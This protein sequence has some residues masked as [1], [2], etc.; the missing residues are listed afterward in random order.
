MQ[1]TQHKKRDPKVLATI[2][3]LVICAPLLLFLFILLLNRNIDFILQKAEWS[4]VT[5]FYLVEVLRDQVKRQSLESYHEDQTEAGVVFFSIVLSLGVLILF[6][7]FRNTLEPSELS[8]AVLFPAKFGMF[9]LS[10]CLFLFYR[11]RKYKVQSLIP[12]PTV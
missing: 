1:A 11:F 3:A 2:D 10:A 12:S 5:V 8:E 9:T 6:A 4:F 7:D